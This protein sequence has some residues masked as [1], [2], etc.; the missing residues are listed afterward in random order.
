MAP[1]YFLCFLCFCFASLRSSFAFRLLDGIH[2]LACVI[3]SPVLAIRVQIRTY[4]K[5]STHTHPPPAHTGY[6]LRLFCRSLWGRALTQATRLSRSHRWPKAKSSLPRLCAVPPSQPLSRDYISPPSLQ[7]PFRFSPKTTSTRSTLPC[8]KFLPSSSMT[9]L[10]SAQHSPNAVHNT[11]PI[12]DISL[13]APVF[14]FQT[15]QCNF[16]HVRRGSMP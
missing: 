7:Y 1:F 6:S 9:P 16:V 3:Y 13:Q 15:V 2:P 8:G 12:Y 14:A 4:E 5:A 10:R 11:L